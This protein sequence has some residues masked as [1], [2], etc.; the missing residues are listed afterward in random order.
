MGERHNPMMA[1]FV[2]LALVVAAAVAAPTPDDTVPEQELVAAG[3]ANCHSLSNLDSS[4]RCKCKYSK[5]NK[6]GDCSGKGP[7]DVGGYAF[8][9]QCSPPPPPPP[10]GPVTC[11]INVGGYKYPSTT[12]PV[13][14]KEIAGNANGVSN[15]RYLTFQ[16]CREVNIWDDDD[17]SFWGGKANHVTLKPGGKDVDKKDCCKTECEFRVNGFHDLASDVKKIYYKACNKGTD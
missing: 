16:G 3:I 9:D 11:T 14:A 10:P 1:K 2:L 6:K 7:C 17:G 12:D 4:T 8:S 13:N 15:F 5:S